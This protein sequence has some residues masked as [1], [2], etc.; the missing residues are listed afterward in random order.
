[1]IRYSLIIPAYNE[2]ERIGPVLDGMR[3]PSIE[4]ILVCDGNDR[5]PEIVE[6]YTRQHPELAIRCLKYALRLG[7]GGGI[8]AGLAE[9]SA[10]DVGFMD[11]DGSTSVNQ[12][13]DLF[14]MISSVDGAI[15]SRWVPGA[16]IDIPQSLARRLQSRVF[17]ALIR[18][19]FGLPYRDTQCGAKVFRRSALDPV[20][21]KISSRG[22]EFDVELLWRLSRAGF[23]VVEC[24]IVWRDM[25]H[26]RVRSSDT[27]LMLTRLLWIRIRGG[28]E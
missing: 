16:R 8:L 17:N 11:A 12:M 26:S 23:R 28:T 3:E 22:F 6:E 2:E 7:K 10:Q 20:L 4:Y 9:A 13:I 24:P 18:A 14:R 1:M 5:T 27:L 15:G 19:L 21:G 25:G